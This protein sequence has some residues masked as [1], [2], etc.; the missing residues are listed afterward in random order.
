MPHA[1]PYARIIF[2]GLVA[3]ELVP[4]LG[5]MMSGAGA[6]RLMLVMASAT[7]A[8]LVISEPFLVRG[9]GIQGAAI[10][11]VGAHAV[12][13]C[14]GV[15]LLG[16]G[17]APVRITWRGLRPSW[18]TMFRILRVAVPALPQRGAQNLALSVIARMVASYGAP[19]LAA[20]VV[21]ERIYNFAV[22][23]GFALSRTAPAMVGRSLGAR[24]PEKAA[25]AVSLIGRV[26]LV[27]NSA[28]FGL[29]AW[30]APLVTSIFAK[31]PT[32]RSVAVYLTRILSIGYLA[33]AMALVFEGAQSG[34]GD[35]TSPLLINLVALWLIQIPA[36]IALSRWAGFGSTGIWAALIAS[37][38]V[39]MVLMVVRYRQGHWRLKRV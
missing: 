18:A 22:I 28:L 31:D 11:F 17:R 13:A 5:Y 9:L 23:P 3:V 35:T 30:M 36:A 14:L 34:A 24:Q 27:L 8:T 21:V 4:S 39:Q 6:P 32:S 12:G 37:W 10:A 16:S 33:R 29:S 38:V 19:T 15:V 26:A 20:W 2:A 7:T 25:S 1:V